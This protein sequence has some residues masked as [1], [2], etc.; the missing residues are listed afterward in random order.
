MDLM[1]DGEKTHPHEAHGAEIL[2][3]KEASVGVTA[4]QEKFCPWLVPP[5]KE[6]GKTRIDDP[7]H[8]RFGFAEIPG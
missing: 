7:G 3:W 5:Q 2:P 6:Q 8:D 1:G 4:A